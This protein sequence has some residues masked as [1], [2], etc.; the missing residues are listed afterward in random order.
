MGSLA[1]AR[2]APACWSVP[3][4]PRVMGLPPFSE[5][6]TDGTVPF[7]VRGGDLAA[8]EF[9]LLPGDRVCAQPG[10]LVCATGDV[11]IDVQWGKGL[12]DPFRRVWAGERAT[13]M[14][15]YCEQRPARITFGAPLPGRIQH[16]HLDGRT[17]IYCERGSYIAHSGDIDI[18]IGFARRFRAGFFG[19]R[20][21]VLQ[22]LTGFGD[23]FLHAL[24]SIIDYQVEE[25]ASVIADPNNVLAFES[26]VGYDIQFVGGVFSMMFAG[27]GMFLTRLEGPGRV[28]CHSM[29]HDSFARAI[30]YGANVG[31]GN[32]KPPKV[33]GVAP[34]PSSK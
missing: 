25:G 31:K 3:F 24:G 15:L 19:G 11:T 2:P 7:R 30:K 1:A 34:P 8:V 10:A 16:L 9:D 14:E 28:I 13:L 33:K 18:S 17:T 26:S 23:V 5:R 27:H 22:K 6:R 12:L 21:F 32:A 20:G 4:T 29:D